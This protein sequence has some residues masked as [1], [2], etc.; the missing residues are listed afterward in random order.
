MQKRAKMIST[1]EVD[2]NRKFNR[3]LITLV[4]P[5]ALQNLISATAV[6]ADI[7]MLGVVGQSAMSAVSLAGQ[8]TFVLTLFYMGMSTGAGILTA[9]YWGK[10]DLQTIQRIF[11]IA[12]VFSICVSFLF[13]IISLF[14]SDTLMRFFTND[15]ELVRYGAIFLRS[16]SFSY[17]AMGITQIFLGMI[18]SMEKARLSA[19]ISSIGL[20]L[21]ILLN[22]LCIFVFFPGVPEK[23]IMAVA[24]TTVFTRF[25]ELGWCLL[26]SNTRG[27]I[28]FQL[29]ARDAI[30]RKL[31]KDY[32]RYTMPVQGNYIVWGC[33]LT[34]MTA[35]FG[36][37][38]AD[39]VAANSVASVVKNLAVVLCGGIATGGS[40]LI[41]KYLGNGEIEMAKKA[42]NRMN[43]YAFLFGILAGVAILLIKPLVFMVDLNNTAQNYLHGMLYICA[44]YCIAKSM[45]TTII[46]GI[47]S[48]GGD[49]KFGFWCDTVVM[50]GIILPLGYLCAFVWKLPPIT[51]YAVLSLDEIIKLPV[52]LIRYRQFKWLNNITK[53]FSETR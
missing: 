30:Q 21:N 12:C 18:R 31:L 43:L 34:A 40:V 16:N 2:F 8:I 41:G 44:Y 27:N 23:A 48:A 15:E 52:A 51:L 39:M 35:I 38:N 14:F 17:L 36:H 6:S 42:G 7:V 45:N 25:L 32:L 3:A 26:Y 24:L 33:A 49:S 10:K 19:L 1:M 9:Q 50:W 47:F 20:L 29:P 53:N 11:S 4:I 13:F 22:A 46:A 37:V 5:I 28:R